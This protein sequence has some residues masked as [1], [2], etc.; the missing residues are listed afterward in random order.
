MG[1]GMAVIVS[2]NDCQKA[3]RLLK[4]KR[5]GRIVKGSGKTRLTFD[6]PSPT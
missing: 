6:K 4:A 1:I 3:A 2:A 5:I